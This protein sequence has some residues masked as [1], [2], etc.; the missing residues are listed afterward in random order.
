MAVLARGDPAGGKTF[1]VAHAVDVVDDRHFGVARQQEI[2]M[3]GMRRAAG[4]DRAHRG[5]QRLADHLAAEYA[6]PA[7]LRRAAAKQIQ[8][9]VLEIEDAQKLLN[10]SGHRQI[11]AAVK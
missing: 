3:H 8:V 5:D 10:G 4:I 6:L 11:P 7:H 1:A 2:G 9:Q